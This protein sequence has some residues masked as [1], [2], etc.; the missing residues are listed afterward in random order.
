MGWWQSKNGYGGDEPADIIGKAF[1]DA[2][3][4]Y[5]AACGRPVTLGELADMIEFVSCGLI[6]PNLTRPTDT[7]YPFASD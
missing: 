7:K 2:N 6:E 3:K 1:A 4:A 5:Q